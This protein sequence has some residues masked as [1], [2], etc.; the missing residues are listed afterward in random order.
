MCLKNSY[1]PTIW[2]WSPSKQQ[3]TGTFSVN[4]DLI[5]IEDGV[6]FG[7]NSPAQTT[8]SSGLTGT[9]IAYDYA[10][11][12]NVNLTSQGD[13]RFTASTP[14][15]TVALIPPQQ[16]TATLVTS[17]SL[18]FTA[19]Q[20][21]PVSNSIANITAGYVGNNASLN[22]NSV[23]TIVSVNN[24]VPAVPYSVNGTITFDAATIEQGGVVRAPLG[25]VTLGTTNNTVSV[26]LLP[27][28]IT[29]SSGSG[30]II[31]Y[32]GTPDGTTYNYDG[33]TFAPYQFGNTVYYKNVVSLQ[34]QSIN[35]QHGATVDVSGG[36]GLAG[37][38]FISGEGGSVNVMATP[39]VN[40]NP[41]QQLQPR[42]G[43]G[44][45]H[46]SG[47]SERL[48]AGRQFRRHDARDRP[49]DHD[50]AKRAG[51]GRRHVHAATGEL[52][53]PARRLAHRDRRRDHPAA[54][55]SSPRAP[56][57]STCIRWTVCYWARAAS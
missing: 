30:L 26:N 13:I 57:I 18:T 52:R 3:S 54:P 10:G 2:V 9:P 42:R 22:P 17:G 27:G 4:A 36:G 25:S 55:G 37:A 35:V 51:P 40:A 44:L 21:Y 46:H 56:A 39:L 24:V 15:G 41:G 6:R 16:G 5:D 53:D 48:W 49:A 34:G 33:V 14:T 11:F 12:A 47:I 1:Y 32:G 23:L 29:S 28:S 50:N 7:V 45:R 20:L 38:G 19:E 43:S 8:G 31:P